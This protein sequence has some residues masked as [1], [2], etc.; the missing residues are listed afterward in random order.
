MELPYGLNDLRVERIISDTKV[1]CHVEGCG[2]RVDRQRRSFR[3]DTRFLC[4]R[5]GIYLS[6]STFQYED[7]YRNLLWRDAEDRALL[8]RVARVKRTMARLGR[9][10]DEDALTWNVARAFD[11]EERLG[12]VTRVLLAGKASPPAENEQPEIVYWGANAHGKVWPPLQ[13][14][15]REFGE[16]PQAGTEPDLAVWW[17]GKCLV[18]VEAKFC[19][20][21]RTTPSVSSGKTDHRRSAYGKHAHFARVFKARYEELAVAARKY[22]LMRMWLLGSWIAHQENVAFSLVNLVRAGAETDIEMAF[23]DRFCRQEPCRLFVRATW[24]SIWDALP[25]SGLSSETAATLD[26]YFRTKSC[27]YDHRGVLQ[28]AF[29]AQSDRAGA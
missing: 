22:E 29:T 4:P 20:G 2:D 16:A 26:A 8:E 28:T 12:P 1:T 23:G 6:P 9:E 13:G 27:G 3:P 7:R 11:R 21:N 10:R 17:P 14:A 24:E 25:S 18:F 19:A 5:H 15:Q